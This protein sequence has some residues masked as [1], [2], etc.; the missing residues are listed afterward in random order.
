MEIEYLKIEYLE[1]DSL[2][3]IYTMNLLESYL[4]P[5]SAAWITVLYLLQPFTSSVLILY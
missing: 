3:I 5:Q 2:K 1:I 4:M